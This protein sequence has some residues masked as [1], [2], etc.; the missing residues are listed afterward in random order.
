MENPLF[1]HTVDAGGLYIDEYAKVLDE[2]SKSQWLTTEQFNK[3]Q[4]SVTGN[5]SFADYI[6]A[7]MASFEKYMAEVDKYYEYVDTSGES[8]TNNQRPDH[9]TKPDDIGAGY[10]IRGGFYNWVKDDK[11]LMS[12][13][14][15]DVHWY[16]YKNISVFPDENVVSYDD[17]HY[18][19]ILAQGTYEIIFH[20]DSKE[21]E[22]IKQ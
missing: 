17:E 19:I 10:Y 5:A 4:G 2:V 14:K 1:I 13:S 6:T 3:I 16:G 18:N 9:N 11:Y 20:G 8:G 22:I 21:I 7:K 12:C 15:N